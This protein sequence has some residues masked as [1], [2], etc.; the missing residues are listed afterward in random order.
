M[1]NFIAILL[2]VLIA[3][4]GFMTWNHLRAETPA[5][6]AVPAEGEPAAAETPAEPSAEADAPSSSNTSI[7]RQRINFVNLFIF[8]PIPFPCF[9]VLYRHL[10][11][12][13]TRLL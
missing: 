10:A 13:T 9:K 12:F 3:F 7:A 1:K 8:I 6:V 11:G 4:G 5:D 2:V